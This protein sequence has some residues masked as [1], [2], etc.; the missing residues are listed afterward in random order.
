[1]HKTASANQSYEGSEMDERAGGI[2][3]PGT[4]GA[5][6]SKATKEDDHY[7]GKGGTSRWA[8]EQRP[9]GWIRKLGYIEKLMYGATDLNL[10]TTLY[11]LQFESKQRID[12]K[13]IEKTCYIVAR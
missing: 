12:I 2:S 11:S 7:L 13:V 1:M 6:V 9:G 10:C 8:G 4:A 5:R 3:K